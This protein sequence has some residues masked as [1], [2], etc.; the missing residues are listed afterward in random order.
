MSNLMTLFQGH[1]SSGFH[2]GKR[3][4]TDIRKLF[5]DGG[6]EKVVMWRTPCIGA[7]FGTSDAVAM[8]SMFGDGMFT[9]DDGRVLGEKYQA[10]LDEG[11]PISLEAVIVLCKKK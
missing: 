10:S 4:D 2:L 7:V 9:K 1:A 6:F 8:F 5:V 3:S 11:V